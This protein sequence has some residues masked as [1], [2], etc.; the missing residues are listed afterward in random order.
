MLY[1]TSKG[2]RVY[3]ELLTKVFDFMSATSFSRCERV[4][5]K[6]MGL[7][8]FTVFLQDFGLLSRNFEFLQLYIFTPETTLKKYSNRSR[9]MKCNL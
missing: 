1:F 6:A 2:R 7:Y 4:Y 5:N 9:S 3:C 8:K